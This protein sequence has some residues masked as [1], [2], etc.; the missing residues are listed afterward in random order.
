MKHIHFWM[1]I[2]GYQGTHQISIAIEDIC[3]ST[4]VVDWVGFIWVVMPFYVNNGPP[5]YQCVVSK[6]F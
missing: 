5:H 3:K 4:F 6:T 1:N 2:Q